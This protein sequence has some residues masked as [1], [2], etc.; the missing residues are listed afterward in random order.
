MIP[1]AEILSPWSF[2]SQIK[3]TFSNRSYGDLSGKVASGDEVT[4]N[5]LSLWNGKWNWLNQVH[6]NKALILE[7][8]SSI[9]GLDADALVTDQ[10]KQGLAIFTAD[11]APVVFASAEGILAIAHG[12]WKGLAAGILEN[13]IKQMKSLG[14]RTIEA[15]LGPCIHFECYE[16]G[17]EIEVLVQKIGPQIIG[18]SKDS[19]QSLDIVVVVD[20]I[21]KNLDVK[22]L[23]FSMPCT[24]CDP[25]FFSYRK[26]RDNSR[27]S[28]VAWKD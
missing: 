17:N 16:F 26:H 12:G 28:M 14:A 11:C 18:L 24:S 6:G 27:Q 15:I 13:T 20:A 19:K 2:P 1:T 5:R 23:K 9:E 7:P 3:V 21:L 4:Q 25:S 10:S 8:N 22:L